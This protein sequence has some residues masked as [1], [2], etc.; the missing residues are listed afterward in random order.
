M[1]NF[2]GKKYN[3]MNLNHLTSPAFYKESGQIL[4][5]GVVMMIIFLLLILISFDLGNAIRVKFK[6]EV[7]QQA[8]A[9]AGATWQ[10]E[11]LNAIGQFNIIKACSALLEGQEGWDEPLPEKFDEQGLVKEDYQKAIQGRLDMLTEMQTRLSFVGPLIGFAAAQQ[12]GKANGLSHIGKNQL[13]DYLITLKS[14]G[15]YNNESSRY[16]NNYEWLNP[17]LTMLNNIQENGIVVFPN[18]RVAGRPEVYPEALQWY[19]FY[20]ELKIHAK[21]IANAGDQPLL[22][23]TA[24][25][26]LMY[27]FVARHS[28]W[29]DRR[30]RSKWWDIDYTMVDFPRES[31]IF[32]LGVVDSIA[33]SSGWSGFSRYEDHSGAISDNVKDLLKNADLEVKDSVYT[34]SD[35]LP[36]LPSNG[37][38]KFFCYDQTWYPD[39]FRKNYRDYENDHY[40][41]WYNKQVLRERVKTQYH[42][43]GPAAYTECDPVYLDRSVKFKAFK[44]PKHGLIYKTGESTFKFG[45]NRQSPKENSSILTTYRPGAIAKALGELENNHPP[46]SIPVILPVFNDVTLMPTF[47][48]IPKGFGVLRTKYGLLEQFLAWLSKEESYY[49]PKND[50]TQEFIDEFINPLK[51]LGEGTTFRYYGFNPNADTDFSS[52]SLARKQSILLSW[53]NV[54]ASKLYSKNNSG[55]LGWFQEPRL[56]YDNSLPPLKVNDK[57]EEIRV[58]ATED[59]VNGGTAFRVF[60]SGSKSNYYV[61]DSKGK[62]ITNADSIDPTMLYGSGDSHGNCN[63]GNCFGGYSNMPD[64]EKGPVRI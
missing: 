44:S 33:S 53:Q 12:A 52:M 42:Y 13:R 8:S 14:D 10:R 4:L 23:Q 58:V 51:Y 11:S 38:M 28:Y 24:W 2:L 18:A 32:P 5:V 22:K 43:E 55:G 34:T 37:S 63:C 35:T 45:T 60:L 17:Y 16:V 25:S 48:P 40:N 1:N 31:E 3:N 39:Y 21:E 29:T 57:G 36:K 27:D 59:F 49:E 41:F 26:Y 61:I 50:P 15:R 9:L 6:L 47:M 54:R 7:A 19:E 30:F 20:E 64:T 62:V 46:I 56:F